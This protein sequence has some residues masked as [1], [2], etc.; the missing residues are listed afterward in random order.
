MIDVLKNLPDMKIKIIQNGNIIDTK[1]ENISKKRK[2][3]IFG[4][5]GAFT[6]TC[7]N[8]HMPDYIS[9]YDKLINSGID[10]VYCLAVNDPAV[11][12]SWQEYYN[13]KKIIMIADGNADLT[14]ALELDKDYSSSYMGIR[15]KR[16][17]MLV[18]DK[19]I[20]IL[21]IEE[22]GQYKVSAANYMIKQIKGIN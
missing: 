11:M 13:D 10:D 22:S 4:L 8:K 12:K 3:I 17:S 6:S 16:F 2:I 7:S 21:N 5:P 15:S 18:Y 19:K 9:S 20:I 1:T 14:K